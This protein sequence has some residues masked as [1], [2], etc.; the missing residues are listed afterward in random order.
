[1][2]QQFMSERSE[3]LS[4]VVPCF[5]EEESLSRTH[6]R[7]TAA[8]STL[9]LDYEIVYV[10]DGSR[11]RTAD[12]LRSIHSRDPH[13]RVIG[14]SRN[15]GHQMASTAGVDH[16]DGDAV[17]LIDADLQD[18]PEVI[19]DMV[20]RWR[21][22]YQVVYG[23]RTRREGETRFK[24]WTASWF[25][26]L[27]NRFSDIP[28]PMDTGDFRLMDRVVVDA[29]RNMGEQ[30]RFLR[31]MVS[32]IGFRQIPV[33]YARAAREAGVSKYPFL[34][35]LRFAVDGLVSFSISPLKLVT[36][37]GIASSV[38]AL[39][40]IT[41]AFVLRVMTNIWVEGWTL[42]F[43]SML[44]LGGVQMI[45]IGILGE[46]VGRI[47][48]ETKRRPLYLMRETLGFE[49]HRRHDRPAPDV[50]EIAV[51]VDLPRPR[52]SEAGL[53]HPPAADDPR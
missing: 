10:D 39:L 38:M 23:V 12:V 1:M 53:Q 27:L 22:G 49:G 20:A 26:R 44:F 13:T 17:V 52:P 7:L 47:Y 46:Y 6:D 25:Y 15:F 41:Y 37:L 24:L 5:N 14:L 43:M 32:W 16:A 48:R 36:G 40:G 9:D 35:M 2:T 19:A 50:P 30:D 51:Q 8:L 31:G 33:P 29:L 28:I 11:D 4:V 3:L 18:P 45:S 21:E 34:K 42:L